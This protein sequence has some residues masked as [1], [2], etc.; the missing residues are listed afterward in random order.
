[1]SQ[2][3]IQKVADNYGSSPGSL[4]F[5][6]CSARATCNSQLA[7]ASV[8]LDVGRHVSD[9]SVADKMFLEVGESGQD[10]SISA[11]RPGTSAAAITV[12]FADVAQR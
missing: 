6:L 2:I 12:P 7:N 1:M 4:S 8:G 11:V 3:M 9:T 10:R 5:L